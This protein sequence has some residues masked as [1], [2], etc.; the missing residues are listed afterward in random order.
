LDFFFKEIK[1]KETG[2]EPTTNSTHR[3]PHPGI[4]PGQFFFKNNSKQ[5]VQ[6]LF[7]LMPTYVCVL[8]LLSAI[9]ILDIAPVGA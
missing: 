1:L 4:E 2:R 3:T 9:A 5:P 7:R 8:V 6:L